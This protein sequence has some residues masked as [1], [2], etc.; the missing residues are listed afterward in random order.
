MNDNGSEAVTFKPVKPPRASEIIYEQIKKMI[1]D[2]EL[3][4]GD[5]LPAEKEL[6]KNLQRSRPVIREALRM[7]DQ[8]GFIRTAP[9]ATGAVIQKLGTTSVAQPLE[10]ILQINKITLEELSEYRSFSESAIAGLSAQRRTD[11]D[12]AKMSEVLKRAEQATANYKDFIACDLQFHECVA[13]S[14]Q[15]K[16][17][18]IMTKVYHKVSSSFIERK[19]ENIESDSRL[20]MCQKI[21]NTHKKIFKAI[22]QHDSKTAHDI[23][24]DHMLSSSH[25]L[26]LND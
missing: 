18:H 12:I 3:K 10:S 21:L 9:G 23:M 22:V 1:T 7:L 8:A 4:P 6:I 13:E 11:E 17:A 19:M 14:T 16:V 5:R 25:D 24:Y 20:L 15:N 2:G 26:K